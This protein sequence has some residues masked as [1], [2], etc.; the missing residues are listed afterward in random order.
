M[1]HMR[2]VDAAAVAAL[3]AQ[4]TPFMPDDRGGDLMIRWVTTGQLERLGQ[5][6]DRHRQVEPRV[7]P[8]SFVRFREGLR[9]SDV[10]PPAS[11]FGNDW[12]IY[13]RAEGPRLPITSVAGVSQLFR[14]AL[15]AFA[16]QPVAEAI[17]GHRP[18]GERSETPHLAIVP[19][20]F[21]TGSYAD[22]S[23]LGVAL[24]LPRDLAPEARKAV[25]Y[26]AG[27]L[28]R[29]YRKR[30]D[31]DDDDAKIALCL[32]A[33]SELILNRVELGE[34]RRST[35]RTRMWSRAARRWASATPVALDRNPGDLHDADPAARQ[36]AFDAARA[37]V[38]EAVK[39]I[40]LPA[41]IEV[42]VVRSCVLPGTAKP[43]NYPRFPINPRKQQRVLVHVRLGF[44]EPVRGPILLG[45]GRYQGMGLCAP[46]DD[47]AEV[48]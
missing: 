40:G 4:V 38:I 25:L 29:E 1:V 39:H 3:A 12:L 18:E 6:H 21:V 10:E 19:L 34:D 8:A 37:T 27:S 24:V 9:T 26:A 36:R 2:I 43:R 11:L 45:A 32:S 17:S 16:K 35:L 33:D 14:K 46:V 5:A 28:E 44:A 22:G 7:L 41:P 13:A 47:L 23:L 20:P 31:D 30:H 15:M 42:D 48:P